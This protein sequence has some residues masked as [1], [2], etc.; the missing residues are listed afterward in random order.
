MDGRNCTKC[1][2]WKSRSD[3]HAHK[4][5]KGGI[6]TVCR[7]CRQPLSASN[8]KNTSLEYRLW[9]RAKRRAKVKGLAFN[10]EISDIK[11]PK[12]CP[13]FGVP[14]V[15][16]TEYAASLDRIDSSKGYTKDNIQ[17]ISNKANILKNDA[18]LSEL[19]MFAEWVAAL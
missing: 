7:Q 6:N 3:F 4:Q 15:V 17:V 16:N 12:V 13:V 8:Y 2:V 9:Y 5:C 14:M 19:K 18:T 1:G 10:L 11:I